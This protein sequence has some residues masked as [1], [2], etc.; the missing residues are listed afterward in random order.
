ML[1]ALGFS[2]MAAAALAGIA[3]AGSSGEMIRKDV[4]VSYRDLDL[5]S[6]SGARVMLVRITIAAKEACG[7][8]PYFYSYYSS[9]PMLAQHEFAKCQAEAIQHAVTSLRAPAIAKLYAM[10]G[11]AQAP[12]LAS[13]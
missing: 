6:E 3:S 7:G 4:P 5:N 10:N 8:S 9:A 12:R 13:Y 1:R 11:S 2:L